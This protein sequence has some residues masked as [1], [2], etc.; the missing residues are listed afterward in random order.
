MT[1]VSGAPPIAPQSPVVLSDPDGLPKTV[2]ELSRY[3]AARSCYTLFEHTDTEAVLTLI[4]PRGWRF[5][6]SHQDRVTEAV[7]HPAFDTEC[8]QNMVNEL[9]VELRSGLVAISKLKRPA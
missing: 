3:A 7:L 1:K 2:G 4:A 6:R 9:L 5:L 8:E